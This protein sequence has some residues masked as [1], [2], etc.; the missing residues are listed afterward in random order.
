[1]RNLI[2]CRREVCVRTAIVWLIIAIAQSLASDDVATTEAQQPRQLIIRL[3]DA[4]TN[5]PVSGVVRII[6][7]ADGRQLRLPELISRGNGW[8]T[9]PAQAE[10]KVPAA[11]LTIEAVRGL[12]TELARGD[13][14][15]TNAP[16]SPVT[17]RLKRFHNARRNGWRNGNTHLHLHDRSRVD[18]ER[19]LR[20]VPESDGL[21]LVYLS[22]LRRIPE[23]S[24]YISNEIVE[25]ALDG[26]ALTALST[27]GVLLRPGE[28]H[29]HNFG[30]HGEGFGHV[31][32]LDI[33]KLIRPVS[34]G[35]GIMRSGTDGIPLQHGIR[36]ARNDGATIVWCHSTSGFED[37]PNWLAGTLHAQNYYDGANTGGYHDSFYR[38]LNLGM[39][40]PFSTGTD[41]FIYDFSRV[42]VELKAPLTSEAWLRQLAAG[43]SFITNGPLLE[44]HAGRH[45]VGDIVQISE[46]QEVNVTAKASGRSDFD[47][48]ELIRN[49]EVI[50]V[51]D[52][53]PV[54]GHYAATL[55]EHLM[56]DEPCWLAIRTPVDGERNA[57]DRP[58][59]SHSSPLYFDFQGNRPFAPEIALDLILEIEESLQT[60]R[61]QAV[62]FND[63]E[64]GSVVRVYR[65]GIRILR[66]KLEEHG[67]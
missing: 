28:E 64:E 27:I 1:M 45:S 20:E 21:E 18:A 37:I 46:A 11:S 4:D 17:L 55:D 52:A 15:T 5:T 3:V 13:V 23:E 49:G 40:I 51:A 34:I 61:A 54:E 50:A 9:M 62:F 41:W 24:T 60:I 30:R 10:V 57:F 42:Y 14:N 26:D 16:T 65:E 22:H 36:E 39:Q 67:Y 8:H 31:M 47:S 59:F 53:Q 38:Y 6:Q 29:R 2:A 66:E 63:G 43:R 7:Q 25:Q 48:L 44:L 58:I 33:T 32:L 35:P 56:I 12:E 19:Y